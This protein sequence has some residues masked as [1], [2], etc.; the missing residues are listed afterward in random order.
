MAP[1]KDPKP[2]PLVIHV[3]RQFKAD[4]LNDER[5]QMLEMTNRWLRMERELQGAFSALAMEIAEMQA[6]GEAVSAWKLHQLSRYKALI[7]QVNTQLAEYGRYSEH[8]IAGKQ[9]EYLALAMQHSSES[10]MATYA[11]FGK[12]AAAF[13]R[14][15]V[16]AVEFMVGMAG[17]GSSLAK[18][19]AE[20]YPDAVQG[21]TNELLRAIVRGQN[22]NETA[23]AMAHGF[24]V[25]FDR[26]INIA[27]TEQLRVYRESSRMF[28]QN[29]GVS[30]GYLRVSARD[31][32]VCPACLFADDGT[33]YPLT[34]PFEEHPQGRCTAAPQII[35]LPVVQWE[36]GAT[37]FVGQPEAD[38]IDI[39]GKSAWEA[40][41]NNA[42]NLEDMVSRKDNE[43]WGAML[44]PT[45]LKQLLH[46]H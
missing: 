29:S 15:P 43:T 6:N 10:I 8:L 44:V 22:P 45:P 19:L 11:S 37:W 24:G 28:Y 41:K 27:R 26:A 36:S 34:T 3:M 1:R 5:A 4:L 17:D 46:N 18:L 35:G 40:W 38:Q 16:S 42:F 33:L 39:L 13:D 20:S 9:A 21:L 7:D 12:V 14:L 30:A 2:D 31:N 25:G 32:R 23:R